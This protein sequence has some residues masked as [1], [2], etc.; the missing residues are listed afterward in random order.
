MSGCA[1][2][3]VDTWRHEINRSMTWETQG[4]E[5]SILSNGGRGGNANGGQRGEL[6]YLLVAH[7]LQNCQNAKNLK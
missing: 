1:R 5:Q 4:T 2:Y 3:G 7:I 6:R